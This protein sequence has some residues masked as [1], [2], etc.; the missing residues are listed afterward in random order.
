[1]KLPTLFPLLALFCALLPAA[2]LAQTR[3]TIPT[4]TVGDP[5][6]PADSN[7]HGSLS[8]EYHIGKYEVT[9]REYTAFLNAVAASDPHKLYSTGSGGMESLGEI[10]RSGSDGSYRYATSDPDKPVREVTFFSAA[11]FA[12]WLTNGQPTGPQNASTTE[13]GMYELGGVTHPTDGTLSR[14]RDFAEGESGV[15]VASVDEWVKAAYYDPDGGTNGSGGYQ[16]FPTGDN[17]IAF[18]PPGAGMNAN[19]ANAVPNGETTRVGAYENSPSPYGTFDQGGN[20]WEWTDTSAEGSK[21]QRLGG[22]YSSGKS[23]LKYGD[24]PD[25]ETAT[26][27]RI[28]FRVTS[29]EPIRALRIPTVTVGDPGNPGDLLNNGSVPYEYEIGKYEVT[30]REYTAFLNA[31]AATD[32]HNLYSTGPGSMESLGEI[33]RS[34][35]DGSYRY[36]TSAPTKPVREVNFFSAARFANWLTNGQPTGPQIAST[37][38]SG[39]YNL[40]GNTNPTGRTLSRELDFAQGE[41]GFAIASMD[42]WVKAAY[43]D[44]DGGE[45]GAGEYQST[46]TGKFIFA[47]TPPGEPYDANFDNV[48]SNDT[49]PVGAYKASPGPYGTFDQAGN[50]WEW[51]D[52]SAGNA[53]RQRLGGSYSSNSSVFHPTKYNLYSES[54]TST[55]PRVGFRVTSHGVDTNAFKLTL[56][57]NANGAVSPAT[58]VRAS[59]TEVTVTATPD[60]GYL[61]DAWSGDAG[62]AAS[63]I[64]VTLDRDKSITASFKKDTRDPDQDS[65]T[66]FE[67]VV[68]H[69]TNPGAADT[70]GDGLSDGAVVA[71]GFDPT[72]DFSSLLTEG[73]LEVDSDDNGL[74]DSF[75]NSPDPT[76]LAGL[77]Y[78]P[79]TDGN[80]LTDSFQSAPEAATLNALGYYTQQ[81]LEDGRPGSITIAA[82]PQGGVTLKLQI[83]RSEDLVEWTS[84]PADLV[85][86]P[87]TLSGEKEFFRFRVEE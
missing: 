69:G 25:S 81:S 30:N 45:N 23:T 22:A 21:R 73:N 67:E 10:I 70:S 52:T 15:A 56:Q 1:M 40:A 61:F 65:L 33:T 62:G 41:S 82:D 27:P 7:N 19:F 44:S 80:G 66:T 53:T 18:S 55:N 35:S 14:E 76:T 59:G 4:V 28:G 8:Y 83:E 31:V 71:A 50:V 54:E 29:L 63:P 13:S 72:T 16:E 17:A 34:G 84:A 5:N 37:T 57:A 9:N 64:T 85:E 74:T 26:N 77:G 58:S 2:S 49:T 12:N 75:Q 39:M 48:V 78:Y 42:E 68:Q 46:P 79:D 11:R 32:L 51:T 87:L 36:T 6:N 47:S 20:V 24:Y 60:A 86:V 3:V 38:E 43:Y